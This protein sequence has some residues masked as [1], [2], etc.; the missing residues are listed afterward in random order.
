MN[1]HKQE[2][3]GPKCGPW[4]GDKCNLDRSRT[5]TDKEKHSFKIRK[6]GLNTRLCWEWLTS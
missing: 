6:L 2:G 3:G 4:M 5:N 1:R